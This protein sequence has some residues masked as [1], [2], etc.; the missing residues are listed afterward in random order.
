MA[1]FHD[2]ADKAGPGRSVVGW[3]LPEDDRRRLLD[4]FSPR[5]ARTVADHVT[6]AARVASDTRPP[7]DVDA[8]VVGHADDGQGVEALAVAVEGSRARPD[9]STFHITW[10]LA[11][12]R[13]AKESNDV[14]ASRGWTSLEEPIPIHLVGAR[15]P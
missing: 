9:G 3:K 5:Y 13:M 6:L 10:S 14:L 2:I 15:F 11:K 4:R 8:V 1:S 12:G 7:D